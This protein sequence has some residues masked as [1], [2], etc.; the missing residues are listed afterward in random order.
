MSILLII[1]D[2]VV[3]L[4][5]RSVLGGSQL[6]LMTATSATEGLSLFQQHR[7]DVVLL[8]VDLPD[9]S[10][11]ET[12]RRLRQINAKVP[13]LFVTSSSTTATAIEAMALG[14]YDYLLKPIRAE[15]LARL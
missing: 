11:L 15:A 7:L 10:G 13:V 2:E 8:D 4:E 12:L 14:A 1:D 5:F 6:T 9:L 3:V